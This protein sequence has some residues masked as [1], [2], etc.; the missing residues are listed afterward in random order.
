MPSCKTVVSFFVPFTKKVVESNRYDKEVSYIWAKTYYE[1]N[2]MIN[3]LTGELVEYLK[4]FNATA[5]TVQATHGFDEQLLKG[6]WSHKSAAYIAG[7]GELGVHS[8]LI[9]EKGCAGRLGTVF[10]DI[11]IEA[12]KK[13]ISEKSPCLYYL[14]GSCLECVDN[15]PTNA[16]SIDDLNR[17][18]CYEKCLLADNIY[19]DL[20]P[21]DSCGKCSIGP[22]AYFE[23]MVKVHQ[24]LFLYKRHS[25]RDAFY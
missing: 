11:D 13:Q 18:L 4:D 12:S 14:N 25:K 6:Q 17:A 1:C 2:K 10:L 8:L 9:T 23:W 16:L 15:C 7:L 22:C 20:G 21:C 3:N 19:T 24:K 5:A